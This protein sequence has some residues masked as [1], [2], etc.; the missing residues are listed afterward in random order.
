M[1]RPSWDEYFS[2]IAVDV[3][4]RST[5]IRHKFGAVIVNEKQEI[6]ATGYNGV[7]RGALHCDEIGCIKDEQG[8]ESGT[9]HE[10]CPA[11][12]AEQNAL[13]QA[14]RQS[15][16]CTLYVN[17]FPCR[18]CARLMVNAGVKRVVVSDEYT[19]QEGLEVLKNSGVIVSHIKL[20][21]EE[22]MEEY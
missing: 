14:G 17:G 22:M 19:D 9:G 20:D 18:I 4:E 13:I 10:I 12:H 8:I 2:R 15:L 7:V 16:N 1:S 21:K 5:C 3:A 11:V 6:V